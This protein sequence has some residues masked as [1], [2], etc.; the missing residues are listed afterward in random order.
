MSEYTKDDVIYGVSLAGETDIYLFKEGT[1]T[2][3]YKFLGSHHITYDNREGILFAV[4]A[5]NAQSVSVMGDFNNW[6]SSSH[7]LSQRWDSS[8][9]WEGFIPNV[10]ENT[11]YKY[12]IITSDGKLL[13]K[14][15]PF[16][17]FSEI[18]PATG[19]VVY[20]LAKYKWHDE[21]WLMSRKKYNSY[22][23]PTN[24]YEMHVG[25]W[26]R[27]ANNDFM[28]WSDL[29]KELPQYLSENG[30]THVEFLPVMEHPFYGS[31]GYQTTS[32][33]APT[34][35]YGSPKEL[36][37]LIDTL[38]MYDIGVILDWVPSHFPCDSYGLGRFDGT[39]LFEHEDNRRGF[40]PDWK[41]YIFNYG[42]NEVRSFLISSA[43]FWLDKYHIDG[44]RVD[45]VASMLY[46]DY[47]RHD[48]EWTPNRYGGNENLEAVDF[49]QQ[50]NKSIYREYPDVTVI[51]EESTSWPMVSRPVYLG[52][53]GFGYKW[54]MG[55]MNDVLTYISKDPVFRC[56]N[57]DLLT[58]G[59]W[60]AY[61]E[62]FILPL[63]HDE[64]V[65]GK[66]SLWGKMPGDDESRAANLK[67]LLGWL[68]CH[69][70]KKLLFMGGEFGQ[71]CEWNH[72]G[73]LDWHICL[74]PLHKGIA[75]WFRDISLFYRNNPPLY[76]QDFHPA[77]FEWLG[78]DDSENSVVAFLRI[79]KDGNRIAVI[80]NFTPVT[81]YNYRI[82][83]PVSKCWHEALNSNSSYYGG[84]NIGNMGKIRTEKKS[85]HGRQCSISV[86]LPPLSC[87]VLKESKYD[88]F[89]EENIYA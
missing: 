50:L 82:G 20:E 30:F 8:G 40:H 61:A 22:E 35:R 17:F 80:F 19:T 56:Y 33:F 66:K 9:I 10:P 54:N 37:Y 77:G 47:S 2:A 74:E 27:K 28:S 89:N 5:P 79:D 6:N 59:M 55:W 75:T 78:C 21:Q 76:E 39:A 31:W 41:S 14:A 36:M 15:D 26:R 16:A 34:S 44:L 11:Y 49:L 81:R 7:K 25:S 67:L 86:T 65:Y 51:A 84:N 63:S 23:S 13:E 52:G 4:W 73:S 70:G 87:L 42:R 43:M 68:Y 88:L 71:E 64:V 72:E 53:L 32:Y 85:F 45:A 12:A 46:L 58:F 57:H 18:P 60:Y 69:P 48:G 3:L 38:H 1:H 62:N 83:I 24:I 29:A